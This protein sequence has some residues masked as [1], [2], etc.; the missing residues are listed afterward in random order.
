MPKY[1]SKFSI[2]LFA[3]LL[4]FSFQ[5]T[6]SASTFSWKKAKPEE[7]GMSSEKLAALGKELASKQTK[8]F[9]V[10]R[11]DR[12]IYEQYSRGFSRTRL[13]YT[14]SLAKA[15]VGGT[16]LLLA[17][18]DG[19]L[20]PDDPACKYIAEWREDPMKFRITIRHLATHSSGLVDTKSGNID[21]WRKQF[22]KYPNQ[23]QIARDIAPITFAPGT[24]Y[25]YSGLGMA[26]LSYCI[27][28]SIRYSPEPDVRNLIASRVMKRIGVPDREWNISYGKSVKESGLT[29][30]DNWSG[31]NIS[32]NALARLGRLMLNM[33]KWNGEQILD[34]AWVV[35]AISDAGTSVPDRRRGPAPRS[36]LGWWVNTDGV[37]SK[38]PS[39]AFAGAGAG[40]QIL[41]V[42]P[43]IN[44][45]VIRFGDQLGR[46]SFWSV[47]EHHLLNP[48]METIVKTDK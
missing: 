17:L 4:F 8:A 35:E 21:K 15:L 2:I 40:G 45:I 22:G 18:S 34:P 9:L 24:N 13:H 11:N 28:S 32:P 6:A 3:C 25:S 27:S 16:S 30:Y 42:V 37:W 12:I 48:L 19:H 38:V 29:L 20:K 39:D 41:L 26:M 7:H 46:G 14:A 33:G 43:S 36:G 31:A 47:V 23:Y 44:L 10:I 5:I 1:C